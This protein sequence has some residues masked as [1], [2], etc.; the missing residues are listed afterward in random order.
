MVIESLKPG[1]IRKIILP[2]KH[3]EYHFES[4]PTVKHWYQ[5]HRTKLFLQSKKLQNPISYLCDYVTELFFEDL[6]SRGPGMLRCRRVRGCHRPKDSPK[7]G[8]ALHRAHRG[9]RG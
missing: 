8:V 6:P 5:S 3:T 7:M 1:F 4:N 2:Y 9:A